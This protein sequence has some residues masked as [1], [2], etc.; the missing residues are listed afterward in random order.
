MRIVRKKHPG[1]RVSAPAKTKVRASLR[2][3]VPRSSLPRRRFIAIAGASGIALAL[4]GVGTGSVAHGETKMQYRPLGRTGERVSIVG[5]G[6]FHL[7][8]PKEDAEAVQIVRAGIDAGI[9][10]MD[11]CWDYNGGKSE[12][13]MGNAL[14]DGYR[15]KVFLMTKIDGQDRRSATEQLEQSLQRLQTDMID[16]VQIH[17]VIRMTDPDKVFAPGGSVEALI[18]ARKA[19]KIR[20]IGFTGHKSPDIHVKM[21]QTAAKHHFRFDAVQL[22]LNVMD[23]HHDSFEKKVLPLLIKEEIGVLGMKS[24]GGPYILESKTVTAVECLHYAMNLPTS[25]VITGCDSMPILEQAVN[26]AR[27]F[28]PLTGA[29]VAALLEKT[30]EASKNGKFEKYK[31]TVEF[32]GTEKN[33]HWLTGSK[34]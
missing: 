6:G 29:Q 12:I 5:L 4:P 21:L 15:K 30:K 10:F 18:E 8:K 14:R 2:E 1:A 32:D 9:T 24:M 27:D 26:A 28:K 16:L 22:P 33:P 11:N 13:R 7:G 20:F 17:E 23:A 31:S 25:V 3:I 34:V 19:G